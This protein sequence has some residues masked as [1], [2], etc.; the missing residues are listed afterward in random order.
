LLPDIIVLNRDFDRQ[1]V[2]IAAVGI[3][4]PHAPGAGFVVGIAI[5]QVDNV[6]T[7]VAVAVGSVCLAGY[8]GQQKLL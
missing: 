1:R 5:A 4:H 3:H 7:G 2:L 8:C 6:V